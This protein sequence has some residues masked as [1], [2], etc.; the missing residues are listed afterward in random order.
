MTRASVTK[1]RRGRS[2]SSAPPSNSILHILILNNSKFFACRCSFFYPLGP[3]SSSFN[4]Q[5]WLNP[6]VV[7]FIFWILNTSDPDPYDPCWAPLSSSESVSQ[8]YGSED[9]DP[10]RD[11]YRTKLSWI[12]NTGQCSI[13]IL[14]LVSVHWITH[15]DPDPALFVSGFQVFC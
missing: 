10:H 11:P 9:P 6:A 5:Y 2:L 15:P 14:D 1:T 12:R 4:Y 7:N 13:P 3:G 8:R